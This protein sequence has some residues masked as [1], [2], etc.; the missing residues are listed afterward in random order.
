MDINDVKD[1]ITGKVLPKLKEN[2]ETAAY[3]AGG[4]FVATGFN[5]AATI[6]TAA[7]ATGAKVGV[8]IY[9]ESKGPGVNL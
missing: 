4:A 8:D 5:I 7:I 9:K 2:W 3:S 6:A 1:T